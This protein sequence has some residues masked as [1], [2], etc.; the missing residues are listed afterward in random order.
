M[1]NI[2]IVIGSRNKGFIDELRMFL[3]SFYPA[4]SIAGAFQAVSDL[5]MAFRAGN[6]PDLML[7]DTDLADGKSFELFKDCYQNTPV[8]FFSESERDAIHAFKTN[9]VDFLLKPIDRNALAD[10]FKKFRSVW[11][12]SDHTNLETNSQVRF[13]QRFIIK[14]GNK[15]QFKAT[16]DVAFIY[17][18]GKNVYIVTRSDNRKYLIGHSLEELVRE[19][20]P[21]TFFRISRK[22]IIN[23]EMISEIRGLRN[24]K[25]VIRITQPCDQHFEVSRDRSQAFKNWLDQ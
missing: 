7:L 21:C 24:G 12:R 22:H 17:A 1:E 25:L 3:N 16:D 19:L 15:L 23:I 14:T 8:I 10:A 2:S 20:D 18:D 9:S 4:S 5:K 6:T 11:S 13:R